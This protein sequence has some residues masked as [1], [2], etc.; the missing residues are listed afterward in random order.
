MPSLK[1]RSHYPKLFGEWVNFYD[2]ADVIGYPLK[3][4]NGDYRREVTSDRRVLAG[5][6]LRSG[7]RFRT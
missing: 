7:I 4:L 1:L 3:E 2:Q 6:R 5:A